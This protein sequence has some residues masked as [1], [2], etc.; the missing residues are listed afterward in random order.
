MLPT[1]TEIAGWYSSLRAR[2]S[3]LIDQRMN[4]AANALEVSTP[5]CE[6]AYVVGSTARGWFLGASDVDIVAIT[7]DGGEEVTTTSDGLAVS[8][9]RMRRSDVMDRLQPGPATPSTLRLASSL[10]AALPLRQTEATAFFLGA[11]KALRP[12]PAL[13]HW[14]LEVRN[15]WTAARRRH[16]GRLSRIEVS[17]ML[18]INIFLVLLYSPFRV[19]KH[20]WNLMCLRQLDPVFFDA[21]AY[22][23]HLLAVPDQASA[24]SHLASCLRREGDLTSFHERALAEAL[25]DAQLAEAH[26]NLLPPQTATYVLTLAFCLLASASAR[27]RMIAE[28]AHEDFVDN[29]VLDVLRT[30]SDRADQLI[31]W[32]IGNPPR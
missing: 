1:H 10:S 12:D 8:I 11:N 9:T 23:Y 31:V 7:E 22:A 5:G 3:G 17:R 4:A 19:I 27:N 21:I 16:Q 13:V 14:Y 6:D 18:Q 28:T 30:C 25:Q 20:R 32:D 24:I 2:S 15:A 26:Q 29:S